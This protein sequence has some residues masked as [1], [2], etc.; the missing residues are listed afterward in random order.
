MRFSSERPFWG[1][2][3]S[4]PCDYQNGD[5]PPIGARLAQRPARDMIPY[6]RRHFNANFSQEKYRQ[7][8]SRMEQVAG[9]PIPFRN[10]ETPCFFPKP[11]LEKMVA[12]GNEIL[13]ELLS[14]HSE[15]H[16]ASAAAVPSQ[17]NV[18]GETPHP[19]FVQVDFGLAR[20]A[21]GEIEPKLVEIQGFASLYA[22]QPI[23][24]RQYI[25]VYGLDP[26]LR[27]LLGGLDFEDYVALLRRAILGHHD[28]KHVVLLEI[29]PCKQKTLPDFT[30]TER[31]L[32][33]RTVS[34]MEVER[35]RKR[36][37]YR[38]GGRLV[39]I[40]RIYNR[41]IVDELIRKNMKL[42]FDFRDN[43]DVEWAG[44]PNWFFRLSKFSLPYLR[45]PSLPKT[46]FLDQLETLPRDPEN[47][48]L[49][50]LFSYSGL[51]VV[52]GP[53]RQE[54][55]AIEKR[56]GYILQERVDFVPVI[57]TPCGMTKAEVRIM[58]IWLDNPV[59]GP[60]LVRTG[61]GLMMG[62]D[63]NRDMEWVGASAALYPE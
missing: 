33:V 56:S 37:F 52:I 16:V 5:S 3:D 17:F 1:T 57:D 14:P 53:S 30:L 45:H 29:D 4:L 44:H 28:A 10:S 18:P 59:A 35:N 50:P 19:L 13:G 2:L 42:P 47:Y 34:L 60:I 23:L 48:V 38:S 43:L 24:A 55:D 6:L 21:Q 54:L 63:H 26:G 8:L 46:L 39:P 20:A 22:Y 51:G 7:L 41:V 58:Y 61:R 62:V 31:L 9:T 15:Y 11:L 25:E 32:G 40:H 49:K 36:L 12:Y 27:Y